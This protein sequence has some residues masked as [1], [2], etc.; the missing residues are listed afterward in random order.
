MWWSDIWQQVKSASNPGTWIAPGGFKVVGRV[1]LSK[2]QG[3]TK[4]HRTQMM[5]SS[6]LNNKL[7]LTQSTGGDAVFHE[8]KDERE[9]SLR[10]CS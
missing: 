6:C 3:H 8:K 10:C 9:A 1:P 7:L 5:A 4:N 2:M